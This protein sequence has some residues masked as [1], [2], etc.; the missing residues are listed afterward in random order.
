MKR[1]LFTNVV[2][3]ALMMFAGASSSLAQSAN[4]KTYSTSINQLKR[5]FNKAK[6]T[7]RIVLLLSPT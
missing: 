3:A 2:V 7:V 1:R 5:E 6:G 4:A